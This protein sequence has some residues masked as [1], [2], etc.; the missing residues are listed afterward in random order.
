MTDFAAGDGHHRGAY[1]IGATARLT[2]ISTHTLRKWEDRY[3]LVEPRRSA[4]GERLYSASDVNRLALVKDL[5]QGG[6]SL[7]HLASLSV[8]E[9]EGLVQQRHEESVEGPAATPGTV[10]VIAIGAALP[11]L[12]AQNASSLRRVRVCTTGESLSDVLATREGH[13]ADLVLMEC[14]VVDSN[15]AAC[16]REAM[17]AVSASAAVVLYGYG[18]RADLDALRRRS[19]ALLRA[20]ADVVEMERLCLGLVASLSQPWPVCPVVRPIASDTA[21]SPPRWSQDILLR[22]ADMS[23]SI[24]CECPRHLADLIMSLSS[25]EAYSAVCEDRD[26]DDAALHRYLRISAANARAMLEDALERVAQ[27]EGLPL[28]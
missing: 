24:A 22:V 9:L 2:G 14:A 27:H 21:S 12:L 1:R 28:E 11:T 25:F 4:G 23:S 20:P 10:S 13:T 8:A 17:E 15:T 18:V 5:A 3:R 6:M 26:G 19:V 16:V 7:A